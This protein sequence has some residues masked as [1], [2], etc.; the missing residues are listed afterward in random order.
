M[1]LITGC[2]KILYN[3]SGKKVTG[4]D[5][6]ENEQ[7]YVAASYNEPF[8]NIK[9]NV[10][11]FKR[12][13]RYTCNNRT[14]NNSTDENKNTNEENERGRSRS[15]SRTGTESGNKSRRRTRSFSENKEPTSINKNHS[16]SASEYNN[17]INKE[18]PGSLRKVKTEQGSTLRSSMKD[19]INNNRPVTTKPGGKYYFMLI[20]L[21]NY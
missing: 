17:N 1:H 11:S 4:L 13:R 16:R 20:K 18:D 10:N 21:Y 6:L 14:N 5:Q 19:N 12:H 7:E 8:I 2:I 3:M 9:Y 15:R